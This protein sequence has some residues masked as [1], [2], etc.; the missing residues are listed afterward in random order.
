MALTISRS[1]CPGGMFTA[2]NVTGCPGSAGALVVFDNGS[3]DTTFAGVSTLNVVDDFT[4]DTGSGGTAT[5]GLVS[6]R[7]TVQGAATVV[8]EPQTYVLLSSALIGFAGLRFAKRSRKGTQ[9]G[10]V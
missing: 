6:D 1:I 10:Q 9:G 2:D 8:P 3:N 4:F 7:F 5:G